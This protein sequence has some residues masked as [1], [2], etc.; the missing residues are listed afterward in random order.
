VSPSTRKRYGCLG[1]VAALLFLVL[2]VPVQRTHSIAFFPDIEFRMRFV[3]GTG[4]AVPGVQL[5]VETK[6]G[7]ASPLYPVNEFLPDAVPVSDAD[8]RMVFHH[9]VAGDEF[10]AGLGSASLFDT[11]VWDLSGNSPKVPHYV[12]VF[13]SE[14]REVHRVR[15]DELYRN[16]V[17]DGPRVERMWSFPNWGNG[18]YQRLDGETEEAYDLR[19]FDGNRDGRLDREESIARKVFRRTQDWQGGSIEVNFSVVEHTAIVPDR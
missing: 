4:R 8:G 2:F 10:G 7:G 9:V 12:C 18:K 15:F 3:D 13:L 16:R 11:F 14:G 19:L 1:A 5:R 6:A 17:A